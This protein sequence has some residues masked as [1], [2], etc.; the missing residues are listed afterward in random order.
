M[1][2]HLPSQ[3]ALLKSLRRM[4][5]KHEELLDKLERTTARLERRKARFHA[6]EAGIADLERRLSEPRREHLG[7]GAASDGALKRARLIFSAKAK[8]LAATSAAT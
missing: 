1:A 3:P 5:R 4:Q 6:L 8:R 2:D 7:E